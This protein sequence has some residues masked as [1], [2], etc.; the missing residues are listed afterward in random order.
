MQNNIINKLLN[1]EGV[2]IK[3]IKNSKDF[4]EIHIDTPVKEQVCPCCNS[5]TS[6]IHDYR[7]QRIKDLPLYQ[8]PCFLVL[9]KRRYI[10]KNCGKKFYERFSFLPKYYRTTNRLTAF[11]LDSLKDVVSMKHIAEHANL[12]TTTVSK[13]FDLLNYKPKNL[14]SV[15]SIDEFKGN[16]DNE[17]YQCILVDAEHHNVLDILPNRDMDTLTQ[18]FKKLP[19][20]DKVRI[21]VM[22]MWRPYKTIAQTYFKNALIVIDK[23]HFIRQNLWAFEAVRKR[24]QKRLGSHATKLF[25]GSKKI[26]LSSPSDLEEQDKMQL[27]ALLSY[28]EDIRQGYYLKNLFFEFAD[29]KSY[30]EAKPLLSK[31]ILIAQNS[32]I[33]EYEKL[34]KT[35]INWSEE[36]LNSFRVPYTNGP[37]EGINNKIKVIKRNAYGLRKFSRFRNRILHCCS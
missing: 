36:I 15:L 35:L 24:E 25:K 9:H 5:K 12:S 34:A 6:Y 8:K 22:D 20:R 13:R 31:F 7:F 16:T 32:H 30:K 29:A 17:R 21:F 23:Y 3:N 2:L 28:S 14:P 37:T 27:N 33:E 11:I 26:L 18:Y 4:T 1:L 10:C 19:N